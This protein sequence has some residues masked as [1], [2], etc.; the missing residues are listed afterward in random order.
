MIDYI[1][2]NRVN[3]PEDLKKLDLEELQKYSTELS[4]F[5]RTTVEEVG[6]HYSS[7]LGVVD[8]AIALHYVYD[9]PNDKLIWDVGHQAYAHK[10]I[11]GRRDQFHTLRQLH[12]LSG[13]LKRDENPHDIIGAGHASTAISSALGIAHARDKKGGSERVLAI[14]GDGAMTG[15]LSFEGLNNLGYNRTQMTVVLNDNSLSISPSVGA[16]STYLTRVLT[17]PTYNKIRDDIWNITGKMPSLPSKVIRKFL[18]KTEEGIKGFL[19]PGALFEEFG[20]RYV[21]PVDGHNLELLIQTFNSVKEFPNPTL[22]HVY[23]KKGKGSELAE[24]DSIKYYSMPGKQKK[25]KTSKAPDYSKVFGTCIRNLARE[26]ESITCITA[27]MEIGTGMS[28]FVKEFPDRYTDVGIAEGHAVTY[29][30]GLATEGIVPVVA[31]YSTFLQRAFDNIFHDLLL[32]NLPAVFCMDRSGIVG[33]DGPTHHGVFDISML[34]MLPG[35]VVSAPR[36]GD[37]F[38]D[39]LYTAVQS[40]KTFTIRYPKDTCHRFDEN[41]SPELLEIGSWETLNE[42]ED[43]AIL[44]TGS[45]VQVAMDSLEKIRKKTKFNPTIVNARFIKPMDTDL[46]KEIAKSHKRI[47]TMEEGAV[48]GGFGSGVTE[49]YAGENVNIP[50]SMMGIHDQFVEHGTR[51]ELLDQIDLNTKGLIRL[52]QSSNG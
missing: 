30:S 13:Y 29:A 3:G 4:H 35:I 27:A 22:V 32:Q 46:L 17:N 15:G 11:T 50:V 36:D 2:L 49:F 20:L 44:A 21:G 45:M 23:T 12:G 31:I 33:P 8:L 25:K 40:N 16:L 7:P 43:L 1:Y 5:I 39:L 38:Y 18:R 14:V 37:E 42:G 47:I 34:R 48:T 24:V 52:I 51:Q 28:K 6:G 26:N 19:T 41:R 10:I 9:S